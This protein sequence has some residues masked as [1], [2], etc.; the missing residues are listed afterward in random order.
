MLGGVCG[1]FFAE[2]FKTHGPLKPSDPT[3][4]ESLSLLP[5]EKKMFIGE[6]GGIQT[7]LL[8]SPLFC[9]HE[10]LIC[11]SED[12][13]VVADSI[14]LQASSS[15]STSISEPPPLLPTAPD[16]E[17]THEPDRSGSSSTTSG[18]SPRDTPTESPQVPKKTT[19]DKPNRPTRDKKST[20]TTNKN[21]SSGNETANAGPPSPS[22]NTR[23]PTGSAPQNSIAVGSSRVDKTEPTNGTISEPKSGDENNEVIYQ[24]S[25][26]VH[27]AIQTERVLMS[28]QWV[29]TDPIPLSENFK[30]RYEMVLREKIDLRAKLEEI[31]DRRFKMQRDHKREMEK[32]SKAL[33]AEA[34]E[35]REK[36]GRRKKMCRS[37]LLS[38][39]VEP[40]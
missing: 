28:E 1:R 4:S 15:S 35:V 30:E 9:F 25:S 27:R 19:A 33:R 20:K 40:L 10:G 32:M 21:Y 34:K 39:T 16:E 2:I 23:V 8:R 31:E 5:E 12:S 22:D 38:L 24:G 17:T 29:M 37:P 36:E 13:P 26:L 7:F 18:S 14:T 6:A 11:L 3:L